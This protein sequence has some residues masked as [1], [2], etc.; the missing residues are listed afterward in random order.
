MCGID[1]VPPFQGWKFCRHET[2]G[3][4]LGCHV[5]APSARSETGLKARNKK[6]QGNALGIGVRI[7]H[8]PERAKQKSC[9]CFV[10][11]LPAHHIQI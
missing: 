5:V 1:F 6:A 11:P 4:A 10:A 8:S 2:Q 3:V 7:I 9:N